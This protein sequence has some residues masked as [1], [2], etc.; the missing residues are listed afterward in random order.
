[1][2]T[3][4]AVSSSNR[5]DVLDTRPLQDQA[6]RLVEAARR[7][8]AD[9]ADAVVV[10]GMSLS[11]SVRDGRVEES[12]R[13]EGDDFSLRVFV[14]RRSASV[15]TNMA[16]DPMKLAERAVAMARLAPE[17][18]FSGL[19]DPAL[20]ARTFTDL[21]LTDPAMPIA[22]DLAAAAREAEAAAL[23]VAGVTRSG[24]AAAG[25]GLGGLVLATSGGFLGG[26]GLTR[27][28][29]SATAVA[30]EGTAMERD[31][32]SASTLHGGDLPPAAEIGRLAGARAVRRLNPRKVETTRAT[33]VY[34]PRAAI[35]LLGHLSGAINGASIARGTSFLKNRLGQAVFA[36]GIRISDD[37]LRRRGLGSRPFD[38]EGVA[39]AALDLVDGGILTT[40]LLDSASARELG[41]ASNGRA[42]R[43][44]SNPS[45][46][47]T[48]LTLHPGTIAPADLLK[49]I[50]TGLYV[51]DLI[52]HG[53]NI[54]TGDYSRGA[55][56]YWIE[57]GELAYPVSEVTVAGHL[58]EMFARLRPASDLVYRF[59]TNAP[60]VAI[61]G[62]TVAGR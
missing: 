10:R 40:W 11:V 34:E 51:T 48:N 58:G 21:D 6:A 20:L 54:V 41:L 55:A 15:S 1:M 23:D 26:Y 8:G 24:G 9:A 45:P 53:A 19:A 47:T 57:N 13:S 7:A 37:P 16:G 61:E 25:W 39:A 29:R 62:L 43:G 4:T 59:A 42:Y 49:E 17:D 36:P 50:G 30:G 32:W 28:S 18:P 33:V 22:D 2:A 27:H 56:G 31:Y 38:G 3:A 60:T 5:R 12:D 35:S 44:G 14:G 52:G 46:G